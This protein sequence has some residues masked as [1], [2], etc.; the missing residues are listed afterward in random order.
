MESLVKRV[1]NVYVY[2]SLF[3]RYSGAFDEINSSSSYGM[4]EYHPVNPANSKLDFMTLE[5]QVDAAN[6]K[7]LLL[8]ESN[9]RTIFLSTID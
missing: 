9:E 2:R 7:E 4:P 3:I 6:A 8:H 5:C 1:L